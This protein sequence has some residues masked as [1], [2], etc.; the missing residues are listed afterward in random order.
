MILLRASWYDVAVPD[1]SDQN[2]ENASSQP[3]GGDFYTVP[4][5]A[6]FLSVSPPTVYIA[7]REGRLPYTV[8]YGK[9]LIAPADLAEYKA[10]T[11]LDGKKPRGRPKSTKE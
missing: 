1:H 7:L 9:R 3:A 6:T 5:A 10:R 2:P 8:K 4:Q 11:Q